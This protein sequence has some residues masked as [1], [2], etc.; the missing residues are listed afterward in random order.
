MKRTFSVLAGLAILGFAATALAQGPS[1]AAGFKQDLIN[2][3]NDAEGKIVGL[4][5][6][7][8]QDKY[9]WK[10]S[11]EVR[12]TSQVYMHVAG[13]NYF[14][15]RL[16]G[17]PKPEG[18]PQDLEKVTDKAEVIAAVKASFAHARKVLEGIPDAE[19][20]TKITAPW[21]E[22]NKRAIMLSVATHAHEHLGQ[23]IAYARSS[24]IVPPWSKSEG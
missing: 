11:P 15:C 20:G 18:V 12:S 22:V 5:E 24:G 3:L 21:G 9:G 17:A 14:L 7:T 13:G 10:P 4:A 19:I 1:E 23:A 2:N 6:A 16:L 8:P